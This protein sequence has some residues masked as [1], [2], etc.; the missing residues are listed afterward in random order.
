MK[1]IKL[2]DNSPE[3]NYKMIILARES[4][5]IGQRELAA[6]V[7]TDQGNLSRIE[8]GSQTPVKDMVE[9]ISKAL[10]YPVSFFR[11]QHPVYDFSKSYYRRKLKMPKKEIELSE[12]K[13]NISKINIETLIRAVELPEPNY[14]TF[15]LSKDLSAAAC[16]AQLRKHWKLPH[17]RVDN[18]IKVLEDNGILVANID[19]AGIEVDGH[20]ILTEN[21]LPII[22][23][24]KNITA[25]RSRLTLAHE[26]GHLCLHVGKDISEERDVEQE[27]FMFAAELLTPEVEIAPDLS[28]VSIEKL[29]ELKKY[30]KV[31]MGSLLKRAHVLKGIS[32]NQYKYLWQQMGNLGYKTVEPKE[33]DFEKEKPKLLKEIIDAYLEELQYSEEELSELLGLKLHEFAR[34]Y[35]PSRPRLRVSKGKTS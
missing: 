1:I 20:A 26:L 32:D 27:A 21:N 14:L 9:R 8:K 16:A 4:R 12:A 31:S 24:N 29:K 28:E 34:S 15:D 35:V 13:I 7:E 19:F 33:L 17:G 23:I 25:D 6:M 30:W 11:L 18:F 10:D 3:F 5:G 22:F 2:R